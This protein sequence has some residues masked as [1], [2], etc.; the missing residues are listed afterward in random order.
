MFARFTCEVCGKEFG[1]QN[2]LAQHVKREHE[3][4]IIL[5]MK[6]WMQFLP[7]IPSSQQQ[8]ANT[9]LSETLIT[10]KRASALKSLTN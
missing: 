3:K 8:A 4:K 5:H 9:S 2:Y 6:E 7:L 1:N 10:S